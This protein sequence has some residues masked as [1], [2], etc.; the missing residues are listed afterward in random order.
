MLT[1]YAKIFLLSNGGD[2][3]ELGWSQSLRE[4]REIYS[5]HRDHFLKFINHPEALTELTIDPLADDPKVSRNLLP[6]HG[7][8]GT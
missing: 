5:E 6:R 4:K 8:N 2:D 1:C 7:L 3:S